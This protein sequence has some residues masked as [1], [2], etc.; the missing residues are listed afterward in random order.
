MFVLSSTNK[1]RQ[2]AASV[3]TLLRKSKSAFFSEYV[4]SLLTCKI[5]RTNLF[6]SKLSNDFQMLSHLVNILVYVHAFSAGGSF[7]SY[8]VS[9][10]I[11][12]RHG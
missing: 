3:I 2:I 6:G 12:R 8:V 10:F 5:D 4:N 11:D 9:I 7:F 1:V